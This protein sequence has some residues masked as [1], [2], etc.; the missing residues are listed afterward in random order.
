MKR[1]YHNKRK[2]S[3]AVLT[4]T[5]LLSR[6]LES[7][8]ANTPICIYRG[9]DGQVW[10]R[11]SAEVSDG[12]FQEYGKLPPFREGRGGQILNPVGDPV[13][14]LNMSLLNIAEA[15]VLMD[16]LLFAMNRMIE[17]DELGRDEF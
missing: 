14:T 3:Y 12:R 8:P 5:P 10:A 15:T 1:I 4:H 9:A 16:R 2:T 13:L 17:L 6:T 7:I 11:P